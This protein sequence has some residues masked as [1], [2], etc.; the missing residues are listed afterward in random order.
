MMMDGL[1]SM[2]WWGMGFGWIFMFLWWGLIV[3]GIVALVRWLLLSAGDTGT[4]GDAMNI[5][6]QRFAKGKID[7][8]Q[9]E[10]LRREIRH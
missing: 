4:G 10:Q 2:G 5:L 1:E 3:L 9:F 7:Q 8:D 6:R